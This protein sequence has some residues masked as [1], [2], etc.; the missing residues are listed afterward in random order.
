MRISEA[1][2]KAG[3]SVETVRFYERKGLIT[4][5]PKPRGGG[6]RYYSQEVV[7]RIGFIRQSKEIGFSLREIKELLSLY[8]DPTTDCAEIRTHARAKVSEVDQKMASLTAIRRDLES[9]IKSCP[10]Q[11]SLGDCSIIKVLT[12]S[13]RE[14]RS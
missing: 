9:L 2:N 12:S 6:I 10:G 4:Q 11:G 1:A 13:Q 3:V 5:P 7:E 8:S 14:S